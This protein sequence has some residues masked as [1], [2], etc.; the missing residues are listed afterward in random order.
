MRR[1][2]VVM[3]V[4]LGLAGCA[5]ATVATL[6]AAGSGQAGAKELGFASWYGPEFAGRVTANGEVFDP[7]QLTAAPP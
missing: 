2:L 6:P 1:L 7:G 3:A 4:G 5:P